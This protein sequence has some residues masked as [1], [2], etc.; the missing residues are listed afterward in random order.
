VQL[1]LLELELEMENEML[2]ELV[3]LETRLVS[4]IET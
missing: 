3:L 1:L 2:E 4:A